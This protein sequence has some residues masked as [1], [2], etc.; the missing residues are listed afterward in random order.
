[1]ETSWNEQMLWD[2]SEKKQ[3][4]KKS[5]SLCWSVFIWRAR[6][7]IIDYTFSFTYWLMIVSTGPEGRLVPSC[8]S[9]RRMTAKYSVTRT[10][11]KLIMGN[12][13]G[14]N[15]V[16]CTCWCDVIAQYPA[17]MMNRDCP[18]LSIIKR[19][20]LVFSATPRSIQISARAFCNN[21]ALIQII[22]PFVLNFCISAMTTLGLLGGILLHW[23]PSHLYMRC[24]IV[25]QHT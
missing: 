22:L 23:P 18:P 12:K 9:I 5:M 3:I 20:H 4:I 2:F 21:S 24:I 10:E 11:V 25:W 16:M 8:L 15:R 1:M 7:Y 14:N 6:I 17:L 19:A 13:S